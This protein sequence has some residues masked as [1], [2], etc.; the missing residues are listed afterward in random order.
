[1]EFFVIV[2]SITFAGS[3]VWPFLLY[4]KLFINSKKMNDEEKEKSDE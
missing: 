4:R 2:W 3:I 1:M